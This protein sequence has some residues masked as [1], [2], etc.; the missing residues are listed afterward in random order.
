VNP[1]AVLLERTLPAL[2]WVMVATALWVLLRGHNEPGGGFIA[3]LVAVTATSALAIVLGPSVAR[4]RLPLAPVRLAATGVALALLSGL[5]APL[6]GGLPYLTHLWATVPLGVTELK[7][8]TVLMF[9]LGVLLAVWGALSGYVLSLL[10]A[11]PPEG[12]V[13]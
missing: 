9:D 3:G 13:P 12:P 5:P 6:L 8:S 10:A 1:R 2:Y 4:R 7:V 11:E